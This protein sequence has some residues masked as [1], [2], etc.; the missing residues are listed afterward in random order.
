MPATAA[1]PRFAL[2]VFDWD[3]TLMD[4][5]AVIVDCTREALGQIEG[6]AVPAEATVRA[7]IG[8]GLRET[9]ESFAP[10]VTEAQVAAIAQAYRDL[11]VATYHDRP[12]LF[13]GVR[14]TLERLRAEGYLLA[15]A[16]AKS[17]RGLERELRATGLG[18]LFVATRTV[19]EAPAKPH[20]GMVLGLLEELAVAAEAT[21]VI[22]DTT[23]D[24]EMASAAGAFALGVTSGSHP[25][26]LLLPWRPLAC[27]DGVAELPAFL[28]ARAGAGERVA[29]IAP[30]PAS[31]A[32]GLNS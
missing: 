6:F 8:M 30:A 4:S 21:L 15:V 17:R 19:D 9:I 1:P 27:L 20:P 14:E 25:R 26:E 2:L 11:W 22:G 13:A 16:T 32:D 3:G 28:A 29:E 5:I 24:L 10:G 18:E 31:A 23:Y 12:V 7:S